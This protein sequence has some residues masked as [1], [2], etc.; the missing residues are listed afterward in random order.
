MKLWIWLETALLAAGAVANAGPVGM[1]GSFTNQTLLVRGVERHYRLDVPASL[2]LT[3]PA[4]LV[5]YFHGA[6]GEEANLEPIYLPL[7]EFAKT[8]GFILVYPYAVDKFRWSFSPHHQDDLAFFDALYKHLTNR[9]AIDLKRVFGSGCSAGA[10]FCNLIAAERSERFAAIAPHSGGLEWPAVPGFHAQYRYAVF[11]IHG[12]ADRTVPAS[13]SRAARDFY[14]REGH[15]V[16][17]L[18]IPDLGHKW[19]T[20]Q[21]INPKIWK[22]FL[23]HPQR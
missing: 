23:D 10:Y 16:Q 19:A 2:D 18:E 5:F 20:K 22:F 12:A 17:Y 15:E 7:V 4:P 21:D 6:G 8:A 3:K 14:L 11:L 1:A 13:E 9:Y